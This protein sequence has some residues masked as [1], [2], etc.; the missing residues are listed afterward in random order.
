MID[1]VSLKV[2]DLAASKKFYAA[3]LA[4]LGYVV[5]ME[6]PGAIGL[7]LLLPLT[8]AWAK[9]AGVALPQALARITS[10]A[11]AVAGLHAGN[12]SVGAVADVTVFDPEAVWT[13]GADTLRSR[14]RN[15]PFLGREVRGRVRST[16]VGGQVVYQ[17]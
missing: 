11:A 8:L 9:D 2:R 17:A 3:A 6:Y 4:P 14:G 5:M 7:D 12:L 16:L 13:V 1:H 15:T 10:D